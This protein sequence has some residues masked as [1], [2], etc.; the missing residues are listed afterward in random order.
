M[1]TLRSIIAKRAVESEPPRVFRRLLLVRR[2]SLHEQDDEQLHGHRYARFRSLLRVR[3][4]CL[5][6]ATAQNIE[7]IALA[8]A[9]RGA[10][11]AA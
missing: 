1:A 11:A 3:W 9:R 2:R 7:K 10:M 5:L 6:A 8:M 4:Q